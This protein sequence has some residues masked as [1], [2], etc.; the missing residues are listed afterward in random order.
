MLEHKGYYAEVNVDLEYG[1]LF[2]QS[3]GMKDGFTFQAKSVDDVVPAF[4]QAVED[5]L[6]FCAADKVEPAKPFSWQNCLA[7]SS[8]N[9]PG[10]DQYG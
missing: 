2:G 7:S 9:P 1:I 8:G 5:Y 3:V 6:E 10:G 4:H